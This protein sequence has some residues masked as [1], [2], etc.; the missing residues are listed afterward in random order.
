M[1]CLGLIDNLGSGFLG[2]ENK[3]LGWTHTAQTA[4]ATNKSNVLVARAERT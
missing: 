2:K 1:A 3:V 4:Q